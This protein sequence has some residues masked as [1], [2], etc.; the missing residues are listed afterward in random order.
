MVARGRKKEHAPSNNRVFGNGRPRTVQTKVGDQRVKKKK[1]PSD[2]NIMPYAT[3]KGDEL[4][5]GGIIISRLSKTQGK[6]REKL[7]ES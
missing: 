6:H 4:T 2:S 7:F 1:L 5:T 3:W